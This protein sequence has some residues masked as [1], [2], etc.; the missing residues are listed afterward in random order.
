[1][2]KTVD[3]DCLL[4]EVVTLP[5]LPTTVAHVT[6]LVN[7]PDGSLGDIGK[8]ISADPALAL[9]ALRLVNSAFHGV[10]EKVTSVEQ[11]VTLLGMKVIKNLVLTAA[12]FDSIKSGEETLLRHSVSCGIV[13]RILAESGA[14]QKVKF[15][16][17]EEAFTCG[18]LHDIGKIIIQEFMPDE[19]EQVVKTCANGKTT[20]ASAEKSV[21]G[22][23][24]AE[25][26]A[27]LAQSWKLTEELTSAIAGHHDLSKCINPEFKGIAALVAVADYICYASGLPG[28]E[29]VGAEIQ[30]EIWE[31]TGLSSASILGVMEKFFA[32]TGDIDELMSLAA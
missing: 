8:A 10:K 1:M 24:H 16:H 13:M 17:P 6:Q 7:D 9:K 18:L 12:V 31:A 25:I 4:E 29:G 22:V 3:I 15:Q 14:A 27:R 5:S 2:D 11:A 23:D 28:K 20:W 30:P 32:A 19:Y 21:I 26:G